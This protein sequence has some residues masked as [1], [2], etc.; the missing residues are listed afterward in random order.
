MWSLQ[1]WTLHATA[2]VQAVSNKE[3]D[4]G[5]TVNHWIQFIDGRGNFGVDEQTN[6]KEGQGTL[7]DRHDVIQT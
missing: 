7:C 5:T 3:V 2:N 4:G 6:E 1:F